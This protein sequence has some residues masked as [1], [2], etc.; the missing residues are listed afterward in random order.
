VHV[1]VVCASSSCPILRAEAYTA[2]HMEQQL[3]QQSREFLANPAR[4]LRFDDASGTANLSQIFKWY[5]TDFVSGG[6]LTKFLGSDKILSAQVPL[7]DEV[8][9]RKAQ[10]RAWK[11]VYMP[12]DWSLNKQ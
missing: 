6:F 5:A 11:I 8:T 4:G 1:A 3:A 12:Y 10:S 2:E 9:R 7:M